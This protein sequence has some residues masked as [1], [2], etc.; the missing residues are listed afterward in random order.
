M[1]TVGAPVC[2]FAGVEAYGTYWAVAGPVAVAAAGVSVSATGERRRQLRR[3]GWRH[4]LVCAVT[5]AAWSVLGDVT[6]NAL[7]QGAS[8]SIGSAV[9]G[10]TTGERALWVVAAA[11]LP[12]SALAALAVSESVEVAGASLVLGAAWLASAAVV[13]R[14]GAPVHG[15]KTDRRQGPGQEAAPRDEG[16]GG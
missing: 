14:S 1:G 15:S 10:T 9:L 2:G 12:A 3:G 4:L 5:I 7:A 8:L 13:R 6:G 11:V 16:T